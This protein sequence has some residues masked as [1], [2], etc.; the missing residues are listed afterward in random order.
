[1]PFTQSPIEAFLW[2]YFISIQEWIADNIIL[3]AL[4]TA[5]V[6]IWF[7]FL[8]L[9][10]V[11]KANVSGQGPAAFVSLGLSLVVCATGFG[12]L[13]SK[14]GQPF[15]PANANGKAWSQSAKVQ[16]SPKYNS[17]SSAPPRGLSFYIQIHNGVNSVSEFMSG[18]IAEYF[19][20]QQYNKSPYL[21][22]ETLAKTAASAIDDPET[23]SHLDWLYE[24]CA[25]SGK[26]PVL[27]A[28]SSYA[29]LFDLGKDGCEEKFTKFKQALNTWGNGHWAANFSQVADVGVGAAKVMFGEMSEQT[30]KN[31]MIASAFLNSSRARLG[32]SIGAT[33][34]VND[35]ALLGG[36]NYDAA[37]MVDFYQTHTTLTG[38]ANLLLG[39]FTGVDY[40]AADVRNEAAFVYNK[41]I[42]FLPPI[43]GFAKGTL[44]IAFVFAAAC[45]C[46]GSMRFMISW[47]GMLLLFTIYEPLSSILYHATLLFS[48]AKEN[49]DAFAAIQNDP[50]VIGGAAII[51]DNLA[52]IQA[53]YFALQTGLT[54]VC[55]SAGLYVFMKAKQMGGGFSGSIATGMMRLTSVGQLAGPISQN[56]NSQQGDKLPPARTLASH[57]KF[58][59]GSSKKT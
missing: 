55:A 44:A 10:T 54:I 47:F 52:R 46:F 25:D 50:L 8:F 1:M 23:I 28:S 30:L 7:S 32:Q 4:F 33:R 57:G 19:D 56:S 37:D 53:V 20:D 21:L 3:T 15:V 36:K 58:T 38:A 2:T 5:A 24:N 59:S 6:A 11:Y 42:Q 35:K 41:L 27:V 49:A 48:H 39:T 13:K 45:M 16:T 43:R 14:S 17:V 40:A 51:D 12:L 18:K 26:A 34:N 31:K 22:F 29:A 9:K